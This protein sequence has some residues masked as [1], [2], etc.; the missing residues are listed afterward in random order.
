MNKTEIKQQI[1]DL[2]NKMEL[3]D[4]ELLDL[5]LEYASEETFKNILDKLKQWELIE[6]LKKYFNTEKVEQ[7]PNG[8]K[9]E[10]T[11]DDDAYIEV[12]TRAVALNNELDFMNDI[13]EKSEFIKSIAEQE[14]P[15]E[16]GAYKRIETNLYYREF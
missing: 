6:K 10:F 4:G 16:I 7:T 3:S 12:V 14:E 11:I 5:L 9:D 1:I 13:R 2:S 15:A 8:Y